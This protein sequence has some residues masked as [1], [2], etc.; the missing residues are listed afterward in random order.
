MSSNWRSMSRV[1][2]VAAGLMTG[3]TANAADTANDTP[4]VEDAVGL[5]EVTVTARRR[6]E[7]LHDAPLA[8]T[9]LN[10]AIL[11]AKN[12]VNIGDLQ[13]SMPN[14]LITQQ[15]AG[16]AAANISIR[17]L[18]F[19]DIEKS[20]DPTVGIVVDGVF[21]GT[22]TG[23]YLNFFDIA[24]LE[25]LRGP[26]GPLFGRN[27]IGGV[28]NVTR[29]KPTGEWGAKVE[30]SYGSF[31]TSTERGVFNAPLIKDVLALKLFGFNTKT[32]G[33]LHDAITGARTG[34]SQNQQYGAALL[35]TPSNRFD[36]LLTVEKMVQYFQPVGGTLVSSSELFGEV[37]LGAGLANEVDRNNTTDLYTVFR[38]PL[39]P[40]ASAHYNAPAAT[41]TLNLHTGPVKLTSVT[42]YRSSRED[43]VQPFDGTSL[44]LYI[45]HR[46]QPFH[47]FSQEIRASGN[48]TE[49]LDYVVGAYYYDGVY[50]LTQ[51]TDLF[52]GGYGLPQI[53][54]GESRSFAGFAD[55]DWAFIDRWRLN[56]GGRYTHDYKSLN[57]TASVGGVETFLGAPSASFGK[58]TP[59]VSIDYRPSSDIMYYGSYSVGYRSGGFSNRSAD[60]FTTNHAFQPE[61]V[62]SA[63][64]GVKSEWFDKRLTVNAD[65]FDAKYKDMQQNTTIPGGATGNETVVSN[66][67]SAVVR[68]LE[69][70]VAGRATQ[71]LTLNGSVGT[72]SSHFNGFVVNQV[73]PGQLVSS[74]ADYSKNNLIYNPTM[75]A[76]ASGVYTL[77]TS[78]G[79]LRANVSYRHIA[80][81]DLQLSLG[82]YSQPGGPGTLALVN[83]NDPRM[84]APAENRVDASITGDFTMANAKSHV[85]I[86]GRNLTDS[87]VPTNAFTV[88]GLFSFGYGGE[89]RSFG[90]TLGVEF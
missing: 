64:I 67:G 4:A 40:Q 81:Y 43:Q 8:I 85:T 31:D 69:V 66:V 73:L 48:A 25:V 74:P 54:S 47:Q 7:T 9:A 55:F 12:T 30:L 38:N 78:F 19:A 83:G 27:T 16:A 33:F 90:V 61:T 42:G 56:F 13:G 26:Q 35:F 63:E 11:E 18:T 82:P 86:Y 51:F 20:F 88:A 36:A 57:N 76:A 89:P 39:A 50:T 28:I 37:L 62:D 2:V 45:A 72:L 3:A 21:L 75:T 53:V 71:N 77:P 17:G 10:T 46:I 6:E 70:E 5:Q 68:G 22:N 41:L 15:P 84:R 58:F 79:D 44:G 24:D 23:Q 32:D 87:R 65:Y 1:S 60:A 14:V 29:S 52:G 34:G 59:K 80:S 49:S